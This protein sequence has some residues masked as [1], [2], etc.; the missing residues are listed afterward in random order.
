MHQN[1]RFNFNETLSRCRLNFSKQIYFK[2]ASK[3]F[4]HLEIALKF[5]RFY[6]ISIFYENQTFFCIKSSLRKPNQT[7]QDKVLGGMIRLGAI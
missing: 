6:V 4:L 7:K 2:L 1:L 3:W 5:Q